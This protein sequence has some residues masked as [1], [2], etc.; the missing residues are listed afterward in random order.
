MRWATVML[1]VGVL[2]SS[3]SVAAAECAWVFWHRKEIRLSAIKPPS[4]EWELPLARETMQECKN[5]RMRGREGS[6]VGGRG[7]T[8]R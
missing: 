4:V 8:G 1:A 5:A 7:E 2:L 3:A 6:C